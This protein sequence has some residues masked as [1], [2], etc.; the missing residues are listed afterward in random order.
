MVVGVILY[1]NRYFDACFVSV[2]LQGAHDDSGYDAVDYVS[3]G[4]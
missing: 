3:V 2:L 1:H 4:A